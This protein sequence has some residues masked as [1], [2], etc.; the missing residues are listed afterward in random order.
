MRIQKV[1]G[2]KL[3]DVLLISPSKD[4]VYKRINEIYWPDL[5]RFNGEVPLFLADGEMTIQRQD[6]LCGFFYQK[7]EDCYA[8]LIRCDRGSVKVVLVDLRPEAVRTY[9]HYE[10]F[11]LS[12]ANKRQL[13]VPRGFACAY[14]SCEDDTRLM[15][16]MEKPFEQECECILNPFDDR[17]NIHW[18][19]EQ[20]TI[21]ALER[22]APGFAEVEKNLYMDR[23]IQMRIDVESLQ[24]VEER[25]D[26]DIQQ[27]EGDNS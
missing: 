5:V 15:F 10:M 17:I 18:P 6:T 14:L 3:P 12:E 24:K 27:F 9:A 23:L 21:S 2:K 26:D 25:N 20:I 8:Q 19:V 7:R 22:Y 4:P 16:K 13:Y 1:R 11:F